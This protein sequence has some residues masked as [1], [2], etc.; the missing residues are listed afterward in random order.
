MGLDHTEHLALTSH[1]FLTGFC[2]AARLFH[3]ESSKE[4]RS[5]KILQNLA[6]EMLST[7]FTEQTYKLKTKQAFYLGKSNFRMSKAK[8]HLVLA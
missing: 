5:M 1:V 7:K 8:V 2:V 3:S 4:N 6:L